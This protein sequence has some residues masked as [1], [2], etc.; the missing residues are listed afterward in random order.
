MK[1]ALILGVGGAQADAIRSLKAEG[2]WVIGCSYR[3]EGCGLPLVDQF[4][5]VDIRDVAGVTALAQREKVKLVYSVGSDVAMPTATRVAEQLGL[6]RLV[7]PETVELMQNKLLL[8]E[9]LN[10]RNIGPVAY[11]WVREEADLESWTYFPAMV[12]PADSQGQRGVFRADSLEEARTGLGL[13]LHFSKCGA[14]IIEEYLDGPELSVNLLMVQGQIAYAAISD[15]LVLPEY[16]GGLVRGHVLPAHHC[17]P[18][19]Q[20]A[21]LALA[22]EITAALGIENGP[23]Y[24][25]LKATAQGPRLIEAAP[26]LDGCHIWRLILTAGGPDLLK[27]TFQLLEGQHPGEFSPLSLETEKYHLQFFLSP[28]GRVFQAADHRAPAEACFHEYYYQDGDVV[29]SVNGYMEKVGYYI[30]RG[31]DDIDSI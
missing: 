2:W 3:Q 30:Q 22:A 17:P 27:A 25:Q 11:R 9:Y 12:K 15:R 19:T 14:A 26:R 7:S 20:P 24:F 31:Y 6:P 23:I 16:S 29:S 4:E 28:P 8:R 5:L 18:E 13:A 21:V 1:K 10:A